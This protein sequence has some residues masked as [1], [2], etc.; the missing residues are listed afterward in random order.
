MVRVPLGSFKGLSRARFTLEKA[1]SSK[2][3]YSKGL[4]FTN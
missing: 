3:K 2:M 4:L 1:I